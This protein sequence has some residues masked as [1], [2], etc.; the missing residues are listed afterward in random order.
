M[1]K[2]LKASMWRRQSKYVQKTKQVC[3]EDLKQ[4]CAE[5]LKQV[6]TENLK[7]FET[8]LFPQDMI[9]DYNNISYIGI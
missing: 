7:Q 6:C 3:A 1:C 2:G 9:Q 4:V 5:D 8:I